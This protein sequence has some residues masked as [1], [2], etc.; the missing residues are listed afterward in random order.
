MR[1]R[2]DETNGPIR[3]ET[4]ACT[5]EIPREGYVS[6]VKGGTFLDRKT[7][8]RDLGFGLDI[9]DFLLEP[10]PADEPVP[11]GQYEFGNLVHGNIPKRYV[12]GPQICTQA[13][14]LNPEWIRGDGFQVVRQR[15]RWNQA[16]PPHERAG[17]IWEQTLI[18]PENERYFLASDRVTTVSKSPSLVMRL[19]LPGH[20]RHNQGQ[21]FESVYLSY[22]DPSVLPSS[23]FNRDFPPDSRFLYKRG[24]TPKPQR[25]IRAYQVRVDEGKA[26][27]WLAG[28]TLNVE[29]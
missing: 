13:K 16:Y 22:H 23:E 19:D 5:L 9:V 1:P 2:R 27:P 28:M 12:E 29:D 21:E 17:S 6:G 26:G 20:I 18:F 8:A 4:S 10:A 7:G 25:F 11:E 14:R 15:Y 3:I 24:Q